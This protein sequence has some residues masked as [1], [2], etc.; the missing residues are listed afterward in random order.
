MP[1]SAAARLLPVES[2]LLRG[3]DDQ[4]DVLAGWVAEVVS[5]TD[6]L[7]DI[8]SGDGDDAYFSFIRPL[9]AHIVGVDPD[10]YGA[11]HTGIDAWHQLSI[12]AFA[13]ALTAAPA[14]G[15]PALTEGGGP[16]PG[17]QGPALF[18]AAL[19]VYVVEHVAQPAAFFSAARACLRPGGSLFVITPNLWHYFGL[20]AKVTMVLGLE[21]R[22]LGALRAS[23]AGHRH[24]A[25]FPV[26]YRANSVRALR[27]LA[28]EAGY[29]ALQIRHLENPAVFE[30]YF[31]G[32]S[33]AFPR[34]Y[35]KLIHRLGRPE[36][37]GTLICRFVN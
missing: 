32:R 22:L 15:V 2:R 20:L 8:G 34:G 37:F 33:V 10:P 14:S 11:G 24:V 19:A 5:P 13:A 18:D 3:S 7:L 9:V 21:D 35:S 25:H 27:R 23:H 31:P 29:S 12:E 30:T 6:S 4:F 36:L 28:A 26:A 17:G 1:T 16:T